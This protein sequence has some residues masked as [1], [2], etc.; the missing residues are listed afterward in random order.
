[1]NNL[2]PNTKLDHIAYAVRST[3][4]AMKMFGIMYPKTTLYKAVE[5]NQ[6][7]L[8][9][10]VV[11][12]NSFMHE[13]KIEEYKLKRKINNLQVY[14][15]LNADEMYNLMNSCTLAICPASSIAY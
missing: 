13:K 1:M 11:L 7:I 4:S 2:L 6:N 14:K 9:V 10:N 12:G 15:N 3:D 8:N 5:K